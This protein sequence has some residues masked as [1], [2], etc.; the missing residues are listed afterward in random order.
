MIDEKMDAADTADT[1]SIMYE[2]NVIMLITT[3]SCL[4][5]F[6]AAAS[7]FTAPGMSLIRYAGTDDASPLH[8]PR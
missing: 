1:K 4:K 5:P 6:T 7:A 8:L 3:T 2:I